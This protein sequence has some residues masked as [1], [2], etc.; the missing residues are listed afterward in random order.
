MLSPKEAK[1]LSL[2]D[3]FYQTTTVLSISASCVSIIF[4]TYVIL[5]T[6]GLNPYVIFAA[7]TIKAITSKKLRK[8]VLITL[9]STLVLFT[10]YLAEFFFE[11]LIYKT[12]EISALLLFLVSASLLLSSYFQQEKKVLL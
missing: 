5:K 12:L 11:K 7:G 1:K 6:K 9:M 2:L 4:V 8:I 10:A 3:L